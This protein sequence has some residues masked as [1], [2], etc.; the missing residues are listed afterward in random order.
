MKE[1]LEQKGLI[2]NTT[3]DVIF[4]IGIKADVHM[5]ANKDKYVNNCVTY[6]KTTDRVIGCENIRAD[7]L[8][9]ILSC[10]KEYKN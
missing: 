10:I 5:S 9:Y 4:K 2:V 7:K 1:Y 3:N 6:N 8:N